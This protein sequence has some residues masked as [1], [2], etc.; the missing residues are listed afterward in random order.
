MLQMRFEGSLLPQDARIGVYRKT[1]GSHQH[2]K[3]AL[4]LF[5][6]SFSHSL[7]HYAMGRARRAIEALSDLAPETAVVRRKQELEEIHTDDLVIGD[8]VIVK[9][10]PMTLRGVPSTEG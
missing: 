6:F 1:K 4:L 9:P 2:A 10:N 5:L 3:G 7:E 8:V